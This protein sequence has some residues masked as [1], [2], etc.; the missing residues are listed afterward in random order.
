[1]DTPDSTTLKRCTKCGHEFPATVE[2]FHAQKLTRDG[3]NARCKSC[4][5]EYHR[6][7]YEANR[8]RKIQ[9]SNAWYSGNADH[10]REYKRVYGKAWY[11]KNRE[12]VLSRTRLRRETH[13]EEEKASH[14]EWRTKNP[15]KVV[16]MGHRRRARLA[17]A[18]GSYTNA[19]LAAIRAAQT[20]KQGRLICWACGKPITDQ[21]HLDHWIPLDK[22]GANDAGNLHYMHAKCNLS[23]GRKHPT[24]IGRL[25]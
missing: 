19:D 13:R 10:V 25:I 17:N 16:Q 4:V 20:D 24:E 22:Q 21:P 5:A 3:L 1:M 6:A 2:Y 23:K 8:E 14:K 15:G 18:P 7:W 9:S 11:M 12:S